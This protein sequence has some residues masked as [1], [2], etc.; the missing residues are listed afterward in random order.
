MLN[1]GFELKNPPSDVDYFITHPPLT[2]SSHQVEEFY[3]PDLQ[4]WGWGNIASVDE[5]YTIKVSHGYW[6]LKN[7]SWEKHISHMLTLKKFGAKLIPELHS[8]LYGIWEDVHGKKQANLEKSPEEF[9]TSKV[10][11]KF[12]HDSIHA[13]VAYYDEPLFNKILRDNHEVAVDKNKFFA[14]P[15]EMKIQ[16]VREEVYATAL[17]RLIIPSNYEY[18]RHSAY[19]WA[20]KKTITSFSKGW[21]PQFILENF[22]NFTRPDINYVEKHLSNQHKLVVL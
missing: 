11:R 12:D 8:I 22:E 5:L 17:E 10:P 14:L 16:L 20:L 18:S 7:G 4:K 9:F 15:L 21:F 1:H 6:N 2:K 19:L 13:S 3:H